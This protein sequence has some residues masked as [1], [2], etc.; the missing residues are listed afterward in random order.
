[1]HSIG[2]L[3][4]NFQHH[5]FRN[6]LSINPDYKLQCFLSLFTNRYFLFKCIK[7]IMTIRVLIF[8]KAH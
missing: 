7:S 2:L 6:P 4:H 8:C 3:K 5:Y 1:L